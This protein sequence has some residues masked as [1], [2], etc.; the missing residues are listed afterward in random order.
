[1]DD[2]LSPGDAVPDEDVPGYVCSRCQRGAHA[3]CDEIACCCC[4]GD[5]G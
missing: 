2:A 3:R 1:M 4:G 5:G